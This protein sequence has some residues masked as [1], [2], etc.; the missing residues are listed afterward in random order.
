M[1]IDPRTGLQTHPKQPGEFDLYTWDFTAKLQGSTIDSIVSI[2]QTPQGLVTAAG[3]VV[4]DGG[5]HDNTR[6]QAWLSGGTHGED[7]KMTARVIPAS[8]PSGLLELDGLLQ[9][10][11]K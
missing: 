2:T 6:V 7:Y 10:R 3:A 11:E 4:I 5:V 1:K 8:N 9:V